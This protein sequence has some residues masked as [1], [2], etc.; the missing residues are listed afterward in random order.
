MDYFPEIETARLELR[1]LTTEHV[2]FVFQHFAFEEVNKYV[3]FDAAESVE[4]AREIIDWGLSLYKENH[5]ILWGIF[6]KKD[7]QFIGQVNYV[8]RVS[9]NFT[10]HVHRVEVGFDLSPGYWGQGYMQEAMIK[11]ISWIFNAYKVKIN[12]IEAIINVENQR[13]KKLV[14]NIGFTEEGVLREYVKWK[15]EFW[16]MSLYSLIKKDWLKVWHSEF[17]IE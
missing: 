6:R 4:D 5:G 2:A 14:S 9:D 7:G 12:R 15:N 13:A 11:T 17:V 8:H 10:N 1:K 3:D 16:D